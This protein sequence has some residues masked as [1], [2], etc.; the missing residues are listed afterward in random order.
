ML[1]SPAATT[2]PN[3]NTA[4]QGSAICKLPLLSP[5]NLLNKKLLAGVF[6]FLFLSPLFTAAQDL[7]A[8][9]T[10]PCAFAEGNGRYL[11][12][13]YIGEK[14][15]GKS[16]TYCSDDEI[17]PVVNMSDRAN[18]EGSI[19]IRTCGDQATRSHKVILIFTGSWLDLTSRIVVSSC[20]KLKFKKI[21]ETG[22]YKRLEN[23]Q[24]TYVV[25]EFTLE[26]GSG[27][28]ATRK[29]NIDL[30]RPNTLGIGETHTRF[31]ASH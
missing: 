23:C 24:R 15:L 27:T 7:C 21:L 22:V 12:G 9:G 2:R 31:R 19:G 13:C 8:N 10:N 11:A 20:S 28:C 14:W 30:Y 1:P 5:L 17:I 18:N 3:K 6:L 4:L 26:R 25:A 29:Y 16:G